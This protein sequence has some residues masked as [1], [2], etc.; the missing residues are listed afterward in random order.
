VLN[1]GKIEQ[2]GS[3]SEIYAH[4]NND[5]ISHIIGQTN[6]FHLGKGNGDWL[7]GAD[8]VLDEE[9]I[10]ADGYMILALKN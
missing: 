4:P 1:H 2:K 8:I 9:G 6:V 7:K 3:T 5:F 10:T